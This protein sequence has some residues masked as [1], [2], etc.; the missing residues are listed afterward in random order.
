MLQQYCETQQAFAAI[1]RL[2]A[3]C[4]LK[5]AKH[6]LHYEKTSEA[7]KIKHIARNALTSN[8]CQI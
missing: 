1:L 3:T 4:V 8:L 5:F 6:F 2:F 7:F